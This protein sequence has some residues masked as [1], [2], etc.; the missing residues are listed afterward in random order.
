M[1]GWFAAI[2]RNPA[3]RRPYEKLVES[4]RFRGPDGTTI[5]RADGVHLCAALLNVKRR[6]ADRIL[7]ISI[8]GLSITGDV[9]LDSRAE[10]IKDLNSAGVAATNE[11]GDAG[12]IL[13]AYRFWGENCMEHLNGDFGFVICDEKRRSGFVARDRMGV[14][15][16]YYARTADGY[17]FSNT[18]Q[19]LL[20]DSDVSCSLDEV[21]VADFLMFGENWHEDRTFYRDIRRLPAA[22]CG[23]ITAEGI[24]LRRY[25]ELSLPE[26]LPYKHE[27]DVVESFRVVLKEAV[28]DR[29][30]DDRVGVLM[31]GGLDSPLVAAFAKEVLR[32]RSPAGQVMAFSAFHSH[33]IAD[34]ERSYAESAA[35]HIGI[36][37]RFVEVD[38]DSS[39]Y[40]GWNPG[41][42]PLPE[43]VD[44]PLEILRHRLYG[45]AAKE[46]RVVMMGFD[47]DALLFLHHAK[48]FRRKLMRF[49]VIGLFRDAVRYIKE[50]GSPPPMGLRTALQKVRE[51]ERFPDWINKD[52]ARRLGMQERWREQH[53]PRRLPEHHERVDSYEAM[54]S[55]AWAGV[56]DVLDPSF[57]GLALNVV[58]PFLDVRV[59]E[60]VL[61]LP[62]VPW[63][64][65]KKL[66][67]QACCGILPTQV[68]LRPKTTLQGDPVRAAFLNAAT[69][70]EFRNELLQAHE[71]LN[72]DGLGIPDDKI[73]STTWGTRTLLRPITLSK[74]LNK[75]R[76]EGE[77]GKTTGSQEAEEDVF[78]AQCRT[79]RRHEGDN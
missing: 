64:L 71:F 58:Q 55:P 42:L 14:R 67:R 50:T 26:P 66:I 35:R 18:L 8:G 31:S 69:D 5:L 51:Q 36:P 9:R 27:Q 23:N 48:Y 43:P 76:S 32:E 75:V 49:E 37:I 54:T 2:S 53:S 10:L 25:W 63:C 12:L 34:N 39:L 11:D 79:V 40:E 62:P 77:R 74:W 16:V 3:S 22:N 70:R 20:S 17:L 19:C 46:V 45:A 15:P 28:R 21:A 24:S 56:L 6:G 72:L 13:A 73:R 38:R 61:G 47:G 78:Q 41:G 4:L 1:S 65:S 30:P 68:I 52:F 7:P 29:V 60:M 44:N 59:I 33:L 57:T